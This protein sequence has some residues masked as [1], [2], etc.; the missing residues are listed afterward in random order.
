MSTARDLEAVT[1]AHAQERELRLQAER[2]LRQKSRALRISYDE[3]AAAHRELQDHQQQLVHTEKMASLGLMAAGIAHEINNP[4]GFVRSNLTSLRASLPVLVDG[5]LALRTLAAGID[6]GHP[7]APARDAI[8]V[9]LAAGDADY[10]LGDTRGLIDE[11]LCGLERVRDIVAGLQRFARTE[12]IAFEATDVHDVIDAALMLLHSQTRHSCDIEKHYGALPS[13]MA[14]PGRLTQVLVNLLVN[15]V[16]A[17]QEKD[18]G[19]HAVTGEGD[20]WDEIH[21]TTAH[22]DG[23]VTITLADTGL[24]M[25][26]AVRQRLFQP[27]FTTKPVGQGTGLGLAIS[28][29]IVQEHGGT[30]GVCSAPLAGATFTVRLPVARRSDAPAVQRVGQ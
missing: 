17:I 3:L 8:F 25:T 11:T 6:A 13:I 7:L 19:E 22:A 5:V 29:G 1:R 9:Q 10:V 27:F 26:E 2:A 14:V 16:Q 18:R 20:D 15:A 23:W 24:G 28:Y 30:I 12:P 4:I 21:I